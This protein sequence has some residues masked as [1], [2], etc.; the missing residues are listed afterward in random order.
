MLSYTIAIRTL[1]TGGGAFREE[2]RAIVRQTVQP[3]RVLVCIAEGCPRPDFTEGRE[4]YVWVKKGMVAQRALPY[5]GV[6]SD[7]LLLLDDDV[8]LAP[9]SAERLLK[10]M[11]RYGADAVGAEV[12]GTHKLGLAA[13]LHAAVSG[14]VLPHCRRNWAF[15]VRRDGSVSYNNRPVKSFY[16][17]QRC[18][19][20]AFLLKRSVLQSLHWEDEQ[21]LDEAGYAYGDDTL[22]TYKIFRNGFR[23]GV[24]YDSGAV[25]L[26][27]GTASR[28]YHKHPRW[29]YIRT[30][31]SFMNWWRICYTTCGSC[32]QKALTAASFALKLAWL[33]LVVGGLALLSCRPCLLS[34]YVR[35]NADAW[36]EVRSERMRRLRSYIV[37]R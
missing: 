1:G 6:E 35:G 20:P 14:L 12:F 8:R 34:Q 21:W 24:L 29:L 13:K 22:E 23:L 11:E 19:G 15:R 33:L 10:A 18:D 25:H 28:A 4:E 32:W 7:C 17:S 31:A 16:W 9:D 27:G 3:E 37:V 36:K 26:D 30:K 5:D 2:L